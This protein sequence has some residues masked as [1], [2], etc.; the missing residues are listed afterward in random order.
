M[1][2]SGAKI[3]PGQEYLLKLGF[4]ALNEGC[5]G[6]YGCGQRSRLSLGNANVGRKPMARLV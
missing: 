6:A 2:K 3:K 4:A 1:C 5:A